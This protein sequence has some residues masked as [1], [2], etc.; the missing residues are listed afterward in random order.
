MGGVGRLY[1][2]SHIRLRLV[3]Q[4]RAAWQGVGLADTY[5]ALLPL[6]AW[7]ESARDECQLWCAVC[8]EHTGRLLHQSCGA[9]CEKSK[10]CLTLVL[11]IVQ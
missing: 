10:R 11:H 1:V 9:T 7:S 8:R 6:L 3:V 4:L 5:P 2:A